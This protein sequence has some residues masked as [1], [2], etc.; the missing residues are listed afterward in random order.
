MSIGRDHVKRILLAVNAHAIS[1]GQRGGIAPEAYP[2]SYSDSVP[3]MAILIG[4]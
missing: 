2:K 4:E 3:A 1:E